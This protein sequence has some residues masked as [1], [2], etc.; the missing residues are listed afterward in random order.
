MATNAKKTEDETEVDSNV[1]QDLRKAKEEL[2]TKTDDSVLA[3]SEEDAQSE[4]SPEVK[5]PQETVEPETTFT[6]NVPAIPGDTP[7]EYHANLETA[8]QESTKEA[9][10]LKALNDKVPEPPA[11]EGEEVTLTP[12]Q[13]YIRQK[14]DEEIANAFA[15][16]TK[17]YPQVSDPEE[18]KKFTA[19]ASTFG[20][21]ILD[22]EKRLATPKEL[23]DKTV[24]ALGW[25]A[26]DSKDKLGAALK[27]GASSPRISS[28]G[29]KGTPTSKVTDAM[30]IANRKM[31][32]NKTDAEIRE[33]LEPH[34]Q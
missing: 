16:V 10:R 14:Q 9:L 4:Q 1:E 29:A 5:D 6:K 13:L 23:Y 28:G 32:P 18:Y 25:T 7:E 2:D 21:T 15:E 22:A 24:I 11:L 30:I 19:M 8:Y 34:V 26:D 3:P 27:D 31:Y 33:E 20:R 17:N 12:E